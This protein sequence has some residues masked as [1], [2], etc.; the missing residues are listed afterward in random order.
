MSKKEEESIV[1]P[2]EFAI[3]QV[4]K[5]AASL[6]FVRDTQVF[7]QSDN[8]IFIEDRMILQEALK[9]IRS[10]VMDFSSWITPTEYL[11]IYKQS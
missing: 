4:G 6:R 5:N 9:R 11:E 1:P 2:A 3:W 7:L 8:N 10:G